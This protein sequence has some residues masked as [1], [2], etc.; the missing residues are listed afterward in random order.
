MSKT[1]HKRDKFMHKIIHS[2]QG[3]PA[4]LLQVL[5]P[6]G[7]WVGAPASTKKCR[8]R[9]TNSLLMSKSKTCA[10]DMIS[11]PCDVKKLLSGLELNRQLGAHSKIN[12]GCRP[13]RTTPV[14]TF[15]ACY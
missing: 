3:E 12:W 13:K 2:A 6:G 11:E 15:W 14:I 7:E 4:M 8:P 1:R 9:H 5:T 10:S